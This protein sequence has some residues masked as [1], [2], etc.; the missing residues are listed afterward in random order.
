LSKNPYRPDPFSPPSGGHRASVLPVPASRSVTV[1][2]SPEFSR[3]G[4]YSV[5]VVGCGPITRYCLSRS[6]YGPPWPTSK[7]SRTSRLTSSAAVT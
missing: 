4:A 1:G 7:S 5:T 2:G 6:T 3:N